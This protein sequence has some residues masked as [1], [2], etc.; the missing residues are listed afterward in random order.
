MIQNRRGGTGSGGN[1]TIS[2][3]RL[4]PSSIICVSPILYE[5]VAKL[6]CDQFAL[7]SREHLLIIQNCIWL[8]NLCY[9][10]S[11]LFGDAT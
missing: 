4:F 2:E 5:A 7:N 1:D 8:L 11:L 6:E 9:A 10:N 3:K